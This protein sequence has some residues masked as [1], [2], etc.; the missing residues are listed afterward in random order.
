MTI[1]ELHQ[2]AE[3]EESLKLDGFDYAI[4]GMVE[5]FG[6]PPIIAYDKDKVLELL[7]E[8]DGMTFEEAEEYYEYNIIGAWVGDGTPCYISLLQRLSGEEDE[9]SEDHI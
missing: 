9:P 1:D 3:E 7:H 2:I 5:R 8:R 4:A 6:L